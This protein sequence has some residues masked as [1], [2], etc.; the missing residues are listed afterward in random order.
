MRSP[1]PP[2]T[3]VVGGLAGTDAGIGFGMGAEGA[4]AGD[5]PPP[6]SLPRIRAP[7]ATAIGAARL[8]P[9]TEFFRASSNIPIASSYSSSDASRR[10]P[11]P[12][13]RQA[14]E[15]RLAPD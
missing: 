15:K 5:E 8:P 7:T 2:T 12:D 9:G 14:S 13:R 1:K 6:N 10:D 3:L 11:P 4:G